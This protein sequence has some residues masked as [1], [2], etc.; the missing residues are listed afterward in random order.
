[1]NDTAV[2]FI[3]LGDSLPGW[4]NTYWS[5]YQY[6]QDIFFKLCLPNLWYSAIPPR[7]YIPSL[8]DFTISL[9]L[10]LTNYLH[11]QSTSAC[12]ISMLMRT[13]KKGKNAK[14]RRTEEST[15]F[16]FSLKLEEIHNTSFL[17]VSFKILIASSSFLRTRFY[18]PYSEKYLPC[19]RMANTLL[20][21]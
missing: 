17:A 8:L 5:S 12:Q 19:P 3:Y 1:M 6:L 2:I 18:S 10:L 15:V 21:L 13:M 9:D 14:E 7:K 11:S 4:Y 16:F 20:H